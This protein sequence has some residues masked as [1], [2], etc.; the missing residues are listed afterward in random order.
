MIKFKVYRTS[1]DA[2]IDGGGSYHG[3]STAFTVVMPVMIMNKGAAPTI[4]KDI[5]WGIIMPRCIDYTMYTVPDF[6]DELKNGY[7]TLKPF[8]SRVESIA[9]R[10]E[11]PGKEKGINSDEYIK[12][13]NEVRALSFKNN[14]K[15]E[16]QYKE[17]KLLKMKLIKKTYDISGLVEYGFKKLYASI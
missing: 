10:F 5:K 14:I 11:I 6:K 17:S 3:I 8:E 9:I 2:Q 15:L 13:F 12:A 7:Y 16:V 4:V 1:D